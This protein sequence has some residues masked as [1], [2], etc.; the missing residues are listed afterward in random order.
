MIRIIINWNQKQFS[1]QSSTKELVNDGFVVRPHIL[2]REE[3]VRQMRCPWRTSGVTML[4]C[5][6][7]MALL[8]TNGSPLTMFIKYHEPHKTTQGWSFFMESLRIKM[9]SG[10]IEWLFQLENLQN[11]SNLLHSLIVPTRPWQSYEN[12]TCAKTSM[13]V[14]VLA[15]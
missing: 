14:H 12:W 13:T 10:K 11:W 15:W 7:R 2:S 6:T 5:C 8:T 9:I 3:V 4:G 1:T